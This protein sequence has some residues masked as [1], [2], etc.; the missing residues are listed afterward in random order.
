LPKDVIYRPKTGFGAPVRG[1]IK[2]EMD[3]MIRERISPEKIAARGIFNPDKVWKLIDDNKKGKID[4]S[5]IILSFLVIESW[6]EQF[7]DSKKMASVVPV[8]RIVTHAK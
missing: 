2:D 6:M 7:V 8:K 4:A 3:N 1:W 5:Y